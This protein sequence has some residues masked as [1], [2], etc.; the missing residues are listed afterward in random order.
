[1]IYSII[2]KKRSEIYRFDMGEEVKRVNFAIKEYKLG[3][4]VALVCGGD[5]SLYGLASLGYELI[6]NVKDIEVIPGITAFLAASAKLGAAVSEDIVILSMSDLLIPW[7]IIKKRI[8]AY[9]R[10]DVVLSVYNPKS[11]KRDW[12]LSFL[13]ERLLE[14]RGDV[15]CGAVK[16]AFNRNENIKLFK[17]SDIDY[18]YIDM[19]TVLIIGNSKTYVKDDKLVTPRGYNI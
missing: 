11:K 7:D 12:Q 13:V 5:P 9:S 8:E 10:I 14:N 15:Y 4:D 19:R 16:N 3:K 17:L 2:D 6:D 1:R 18:S